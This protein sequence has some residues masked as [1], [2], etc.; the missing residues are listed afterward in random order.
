MRKSLILFGLILLAASSVK[1]QENR[2]YEI[3]GNYQYVRFNP[4]G[5]ASG[6]NCHGGSGSGA[7]YLNTSI[8]IV[9]EFGACKVTGLPSGASAH[10][11]DYLFGPRVYFHAHGRI[12][13]FVQALFGGERLSAG[14]TGVGSNSTNAFAA[15]VGGGADVTLT[16]HVSLRALQVDYLYTHF[17]GASQ[18]N[19]R[20][21]SG[22]V[23]RFGR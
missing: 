19:L 6:I 15:A 17:G 3:S 12:F 23:W 16:R 10:E 8:G 5:G 13:P 11:M 22:I 14:L 7:A 21:Q 4:G 1:A 20:L 18:N 9:G 2:G